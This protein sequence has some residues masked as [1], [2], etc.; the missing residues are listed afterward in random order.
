MRMQTIAITG[1]SGFIGQALSVHLKARGKRVRPLVR[2]GRSADDAIAWDPD[3]GQL[4]SVDLEGVDAIVHLAGEN[5][6]DGRWTEQRK[7]DLKQ[8]RVRGTTLLAHAL[9]RMSRPV[10]TWISAS[11]VGFYGD[12]GDELLD[13]ESAPGTDFLAALS[14]AWEQAAAPAIDAGVRVVNAR[15]GIV[16]DPTGGALAK[17][18]LP[19][20][21]GLGGKI[22]SGR[23]F[24]SWISLVDAVRA[25]DHLLQRDDLSGP[26]NLTAPKPVTNAELTRSLASSLHRPSL[27]RV[28]AF[29]ARLAFGE[30][31]DGALL[32]GARVLPKRLLASGFEFDFPE[33]DGYLR[34]CLGRSAG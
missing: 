6:A 21:L 3:E 34:H 31:A 27:L 10:P 8:S 2:P 33:I 24:M 9:S 13:E 14:Q 17:M 7:T 26:V 5:I 4:E 25:I 11:A 29:A 30:M 32:G 12:R 1:A 15:I 16:L 22:G 20:K 28:P 23:Q 18:I 19:F